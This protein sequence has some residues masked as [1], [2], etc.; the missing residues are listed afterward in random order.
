ML[1]P[2]KTQAPSLNAAYHIASKKRGT[3][4]VEARQTRSGGKDIKTVKGKNADSK[5]RMAC[6]RSKTKQES[7]SDIDSDE[8]E[9][10]GLQLESDYEEDEEIKLGKRKKRSVVRLS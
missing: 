2:S 5:K 9:D 1:Q 8:D 7:D 4:A 3:G 6:P 10:Y